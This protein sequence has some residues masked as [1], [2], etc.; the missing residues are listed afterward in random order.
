MENNLG[1][2]QIMASNIRRFLT[3]RG[4]TIKDLAAELGIATSTVGDWCRA[5]AY[6]RIDKIERMAAL[7]GV[8]KADL[9]EDPADVRDEILNRAFAGRPEMRELF[10]V[11]DKASAKDILRVI[12]ILRAFAEDY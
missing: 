7:F 3:L 9:V 11:A 1:N 8:T 5:T 6:P 12:K 2:K 10:E 4:M